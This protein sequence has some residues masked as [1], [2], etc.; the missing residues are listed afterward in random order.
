MKLIN[1]ASLVHEKLNITFS[2]LFY[3][4]YKPPFRG[5]MQWSIQCNTYILNMRIF[6]FTL[7][8]YFFYTFTLQCGEVQKKPSFV[9]FSVTSLSFA[10]PTAFENIQR[11]KKENEKHQLGHIPTRW[12]LLHF[13]VQNL[14]KIFAL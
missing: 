14:P 5:V 12:D 4:K 8:V 3:Y 2:V 11:I 10:I 1:A 7:R 13:K 9:L 6:Y